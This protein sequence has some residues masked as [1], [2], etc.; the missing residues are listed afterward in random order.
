MWR[1][2]CLSW[3]AM[4]IPPN[5]AP[6]TA[7]WHGIRPSPPA[8]TAAGGPEP[9]QQAASRQDQGTDR[10]HRAAGADHGVRAVALRGRA[11]QHDEQGLAEVDPALGD[12]EGLAA[13]PGRGGLDER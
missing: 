13:L 11:G 4:P 2:A 3:M 12:A 5:P 9:G 10:A 6:I 1:P 7:T 8:F